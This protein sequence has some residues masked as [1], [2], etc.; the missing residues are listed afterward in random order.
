MVI[1]AVSTSQTVKKHVQSLIEF[2]SAKYQQLLHSAHRM[3]DI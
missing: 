2:Q 3:D 1:I